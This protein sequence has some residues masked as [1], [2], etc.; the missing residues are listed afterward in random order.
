[1]VKFFKALFFV[2]ASAIMA[3]CLI[4]IPASSGSVSVSYIAVLGIYLGLD[5]AGMITK[6]ANMNK[7]EY[8]SLNVHKYVI[9]S[10][11]L[12]SNIVI[13]IFVKEKADISV[14]LTSFISAALIIIGC[15]IG[16]LEGNKI[17]TNFGKEEAEG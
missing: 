3:L 7:G 16:G 15:I 9:A 11:C 1:M 4:L 12:V 14:A 5:I 8:K 2:L 17:A 6:T 10:V 13:S